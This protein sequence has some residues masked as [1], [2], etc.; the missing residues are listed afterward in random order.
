VDV[1]TRPRLE[2][3]IRAM[4]GADAEIVVDVDHVGPGYGELDDTTVEAIRIAARGDGILLDPVYTGKAFAALIS[5]ARRGRI[6]SGEAVCF[7]HTGGQPA[8]FAEKYRGA[9]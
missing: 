3:A 4:T 6:G 7:W 9:F 1:G 2:D 8:L 5:W